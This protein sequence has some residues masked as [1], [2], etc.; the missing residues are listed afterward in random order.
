MNSAVFLDRDN[1]ILLR[2]E[3]DGGVVD[4]DIVQRA[5]LRILRADEVFDTDSDSDITLQ[6]NA[7]N[8][9][10]QGG[11]RNIAPGLYRALL[12]IYDAANTNGLAWAQISVRVRAWPADE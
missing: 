5:V 6:D 12:T 1:D 3:R 7:R 8:V 11:Q 9:R 4:P 2:L 10:I